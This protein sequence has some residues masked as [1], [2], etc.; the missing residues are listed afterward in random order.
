MKFKDK[1]MIVTGAAS[2]I[3]RATAL[4]FAREGARLI[5][6]DVN[7]D[8]L[9]DVGREA[10]GATVMTFDVSDPDACTALVDKAVGE[11]GRLDVLCNIAGV[12]RMAPLAEVT[13]E[14]WSRIIS[15]NLSGVFYLSQA[16]MP[17]LLKTRGSI[18]NLASAAGLIGVPFNAAYT[19]SKHG[20]V[21][22]TK[23]MA[24]EVAKA[25]VRINAV[26]PTGVKTPMVAGPPPEG[27]DWELVMRA[28]PFLNGGEMCD[29]EDI[30][31]AVAFLASDEAKRVTGVA[32]PVD[33]GQTAM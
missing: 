8:A 27:V 30:A 22:L 11:T 16:A 15:I 26:C 31:D 5:L 25:G 23:S 33:G 19:A 24:I 9:A 14:D 1:T 18:V 29:P 10:G 21:G 7:G 6:G 3:G 28:A 4:R 20:V 13:R 12:L 2:G 17:H 32:F